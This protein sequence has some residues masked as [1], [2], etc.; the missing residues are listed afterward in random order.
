[1]L[2]F[3]TTLWGI[4]SRDFEGNILNMFRIHSY[5]IFES[6]S[7]ESTGVEPVFLL[8]SGPSM[9]EGIY[10]MQLTWQGKYLNHKFCWFDFVTS[11]WKKNFLL[12]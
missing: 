8:E 2:K 7:L 11:F 12:I 9:I 5:A 6:V 1:M 3:W 10:K 4:I